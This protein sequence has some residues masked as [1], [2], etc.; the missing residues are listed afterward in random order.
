M[1]QNLVESCLQEVSHGQ[2]ILVRFCLLPRAQVVDA[3]DRRRLYHVI[4]LPRAWVLIGQTGSGR[5]RTEHI[6]KVLDGVDVT[7]DELEQVAAL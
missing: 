5:P 2:P 4:T 6:F 7:D 1:V 3:D